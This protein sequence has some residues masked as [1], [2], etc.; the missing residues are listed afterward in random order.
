MRKALFT[1]YKASYKIARCEKPRIFDKELILPA[2]IVNIE[3]MFGDNFVKGWQFIPQSNE[4]VA[5]RI[6]DIAEN[7]EQQL[8]GMSMANYFQFSLMRQATTIKML[9]SLR[10]F[11]FRLV[12]Q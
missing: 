1:S 7:V 12:Y 4:T 8:L 3:T 6:D 5:R 10:V 9:I 11:D 2:A